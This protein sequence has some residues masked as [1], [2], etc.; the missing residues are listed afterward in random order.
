MDEIRQA[1][2]LLATVRFSRA[3]LDCEVAELMS[4]IVILEGLEQSL[5]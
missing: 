1:I 5:K 3:L 4:A 2:E